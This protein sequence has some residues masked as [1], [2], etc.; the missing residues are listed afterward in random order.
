[1]K[2][3][4][5]YYENR[6]VACVLSTLETDYAN[7]KSVRVHN[8]CVDHYRQYASKIDADFPEYIGRFSELLH[9]DNSVVRAG[10]A[11]CLLELMHFSEKQKKDALAIIR[12]ERQTAA[13]EADR[14]GWELWQNDWDS[15][16]IQTVYG[17]SNQCDQHM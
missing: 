2:K 12:Q 5:F 9:H 16:A 15:G 10:C 4:Y 8:R 7:P 17:P 6:F 3:D 14:F 11:V 13:S 1:M